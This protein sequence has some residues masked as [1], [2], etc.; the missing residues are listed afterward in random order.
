MPELIHEST[1]AA[2]KAYRCN[3][4]EWI[5]D[6]GIVP[7]IWDELTYAEKRALVRAKRNRQRIMPGQQYRRMRLK[8]CGEAYTFRAIPEI[9]AICR[10]LEIYEDC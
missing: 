9:D 3:A 8:C 10:R 2:R 7:D 6:N 4:C 1:Q 5:F